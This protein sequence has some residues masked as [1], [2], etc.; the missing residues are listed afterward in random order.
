MT[1]PPVT[2]TAIETVGPAS[3]TGTSRIRFGGSVAFATLSARVRS[4]EAVFSCGRSLYPVSRRVPA[5]PSR[6]LLWGQSR[7]DIRAR[8]FPFAW[9]PRGSPACAAVPL[10]SVPSGHAV[11]DPG[12]DLVEDRRALWL[13]VRL[14]ADTREEPPSDERVG[15]E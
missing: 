9:V 8:G 15:N 1:P 5:F 6:D 4:P 2:G 3:Y 10:A 7:R 12:D 14:V 11:A 13:V